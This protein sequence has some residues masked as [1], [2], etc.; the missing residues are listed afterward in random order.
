V[1]RW[2]Y[3]LGMLC[4][5]ALLVG[6]GVVA[7]R[8]YARTSGAAGV[9]RGYF[10]ALARADAAD[11]LAF[12]DIPAGPHTLLTG[13]VLRE[14][15]RIAPL[16]N[17]A[18]TAL[19]RSGNSARAEVTYT[20]A[21]A[22]HPVPVRGTVRLHRAGHGWRLD[23][24]AVATALDATTAR[25]RQT[26][27]GAAIPAGSTLLFPGA[28]PIRADSSYL[29]LDPDHD[30]V[31]FDSP[32]VTN[33]YIEVSAAGRRAATAAVTQKLRGCLT[34]GTAP[35]DATCPL[36]NE[37]YVPGSINGTLDGDL[38]DVTVELGNDPVGTLRIHARA[39]VSGTYDRLDFRNQ[40]V[41]GHG[42]VNLN[43]SAAAYAL[44][45]MTVRWTLS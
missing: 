44:S 11:A 14:Q 8:G 34:A 30:Y 36:P 1:R 28:L 20:L 38:H 45:P 7:V 19:R 41:A 31:G 32:P 4:A 22:G 33:V 5:L 9:V 40:R 35:A 2:F 13:I 39:T 42:R 43:L 24:V 27:V 29:Q 16:Q 26:I 12:G 15:H 6:G 25:E 21:F 23:R 18:V 10:G 3:W 37:R 17:V